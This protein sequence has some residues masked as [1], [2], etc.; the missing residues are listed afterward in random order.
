MIGLHGS[1]RCTRSHLFW[2][3]AS[4]A[5]LLVATA[6]LGAPSGVAWAEPEGAQASAEPSATA[7]GDAEGL[8]LPEGYGPVRFYDSREKVQAAFPNAKLVRDTGENGDMSSGLVPPIA[9]L[10]VREQTIVGL[11]GCRVVFGFAA[12]Q[13]YAAEF[14]CGSDPVVR[15][16]IEEAYGEPSLEIEDAV[17]WMTS[18]TTLSMNPR[19][20]QFAYRSRPLESALQSALQAAIAAGKLKTQ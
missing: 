16:R 9:A 19:S 3:L 20:M 14:D 10:E 5:P 8:V 17:Y 1:E 7:K 2:R 4:A 15:Q 12:D 6:W 13:L 11:T 18:A